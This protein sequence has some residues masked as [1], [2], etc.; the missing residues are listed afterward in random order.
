VTTAEPGPAGNNAFGERVTEWIGVLGRLRDVVRQE[1][2]RSQLAGLTQVCQGPARIL[3]VGCGQGTQVLHLARAGHHVT[4]LDSSGELL[5]RFEDDLAREPGEV[6]ARVRLIR[7]P[8][9]R[10]P[11]LVSGPFDVVM[12]H[13]VLMYLDDPGPMLSAL[14]QVTAAGG[15]VSL[16]VRNGLAPAMR[17]GLRGHWQAALRGFDTLEYI[18][19]LGLTAHAHTPADLDRMLAPL[20]WER[21]A[22]F[23]VRVFTDHLDRPPPGPDELPD[24]LA[25]ERE[26]GRRDPYRSVAA[27]LH[28]VYGRVEG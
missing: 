27:L 24:L 16:L 6:A 22:W 17:D 20:G 11:D 8:G 13:G 12:C 28:L 23:G 3:D 19:R 4:G 10:A 2:L 25:A 21:Q 5:A 9:E 1:V 15:A 18:N 7:G 26:A 14:S